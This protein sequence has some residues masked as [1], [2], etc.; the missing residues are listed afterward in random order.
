MYDTEHSLE[1]IARFNGFGYYAKAGAKE[2]LNA[3]ANAFLAFVIKFA[4]IVCTKRLR[5]YRT[6][7]GLLTNVK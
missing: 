3:C 7:T 1:S 4:L 6:L 5:Y 2:V